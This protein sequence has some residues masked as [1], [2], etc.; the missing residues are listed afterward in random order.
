MG[1]FN[2][3]SVD[4]DIDDVKYDVLKALTDEELVE[5]I[6]N[7]DKFRIRQKFES[8]ELIGIDK[9]YFSRNDLYRHLCDICDCGYHEPK[10]SLLNKLKDM[11]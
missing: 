9:L 6:E 8:G 7:R 4:I 5:E 11:M 1:I 10:E 2:T 3:I